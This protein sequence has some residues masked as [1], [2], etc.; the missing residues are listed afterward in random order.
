MARRLLCGASSC[1]K[2]MTTK[3]TSSP[4]A[5]GEITV[6]IY[7]EDFELAPDM[8]IEISGEIDLESAD[9]SQHE[10]HAEEVEIDVYQWQAITP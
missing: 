10:E 2:G 7:D 8:P 4:M 3:N 1:G 5:Q 6:E 9:H